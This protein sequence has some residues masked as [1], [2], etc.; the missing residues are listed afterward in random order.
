MK[1]HYYADTD[2]LHVDLESG[3]GIET[4]EVADGLSVDLDANGDVVGVDMDNASKGLD[5]LESGIRREIA[6]ALYRD[7]GLSLGRAARW[8]GF[9]TGEFIRH[10]SRLGIPVVA[11]SSD[12]VRDDA[13]AVDA[14]RKGS[15]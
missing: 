13:E 7:Q 15:S 6:T 5:L 1:L 10:V 8:S 14:W 2:S 3:P 11:G 4:R 12:S 9:N